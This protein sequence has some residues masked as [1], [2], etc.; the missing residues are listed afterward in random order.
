MGNDPWFFATQGFESIKYD[1]YLKFVLEFS[2]VVTCVTAFSIPLAERTNLIA[3][4]GYAF[5]LSGFIYPALVSW[6][7]G[8]GWL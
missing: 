1:H 5:I 8:G 6:I 7:W 3:Y 2:Y 4:L